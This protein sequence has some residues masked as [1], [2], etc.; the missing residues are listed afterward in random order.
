VKILAELICWQ[1]RRFAFNDF[2]HLKEYRFPLGVRV[3]TSCKFHLIKI[4]NQP[5]TTHT[6]PA[7]THTTIYHNRANNYV[8]IMPFKQFRHSG[9]HNILS[10]LEGAR[11]ITCNNWATGIY[12]LHDWCWA[13]LCKYHMI[14]KLKQ[15]T[16]SI[17]SLLIWTIAQTLWNT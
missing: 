17:T 5:T 15:H 1:L 16:I 10:G 9:E 4:N 2:L 8:H 3:F 14:W 13:P 6:Q 7:S 11:Q 12:R